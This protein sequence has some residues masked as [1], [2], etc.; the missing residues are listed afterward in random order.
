MVLSIVVRKWAILWIEC[1]YLT[2][3]QPNKNLESEFNLSFCGYNSFIRKS[4]SFNDHYTVVPRFKV[5]PD[6]PCPLHFLREPAFIFVQINDELTPIYRFSRVHRAF[7]FFFQW[8]F[9]WWSCLRIS[10]DDDVFLEVHDWSSPI[11]HVYWKWMLQ[12]CT[13]ASVL[14]SKVMH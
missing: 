1:P 3:F 14:S 5:Y 6:L 10:G 4:S 8:P 11:T 7:S 13:I 2:V 12:H 9:Q